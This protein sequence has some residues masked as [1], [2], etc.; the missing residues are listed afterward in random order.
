MRTLLVGVLFLATAAYPETRKQVGATREIGRGAGS[1]ATGAAKGTGE[2][3]KGAGV[4]ALDLVTLH[5]I[6]AGVSVGRGAVVG[7]ADVAVGAVKG[8]AQ[9]TKGVGKAIRKIL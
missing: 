3:A 5:P 4:G 2:V 1:I 9:I 6:D 7:G 8:T